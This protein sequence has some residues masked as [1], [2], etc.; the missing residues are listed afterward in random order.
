MVFATGLIE[1]LNG[2]SLLCRCGR[3]RVWAGAVRSPE[4]SQQL[5]DWYSLSH[6]VHGLLLYGAARLALRRRRLGTRVIAA[7]LI[8]CAW[9]A[10]EN[11]SWVIDR[12]RAET[13]S[14]GYSGDS[15]LNSV[16]DVL[17][18]LLGFFL[19]SRLPAVWSIALGLALEL[20]SLAAIRDNLA[21]NILMLVHPIGP[22]RSWQ[23][24]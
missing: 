9:E 20:V 22:V 17:F 7:A 4:N 14:W 10:V 5:A 19:A 23:G 2:R 12:Y 21:L 13:V 6:V 1:L 16:G 15:V 8:E 11:T 24:G 18:M 3:V